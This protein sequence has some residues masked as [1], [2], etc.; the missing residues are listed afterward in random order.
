[1]FQIY[2]SSFTHGI[3]DLVPFGP[4]SM[5]L[6]NT[7][8]RQAA[9]FFSEDTKKVYFLQAARNNAA[10]QGHAMDGMF[11]GNFWG[12]KVE[13]ALVMSVDVT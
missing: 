4:S 8:R 12:S 6:T 5:Y 9:S 13:G 10:K 7:L 3:S 11:R 2:P 1:V